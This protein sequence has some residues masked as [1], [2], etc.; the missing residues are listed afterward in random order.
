[1][2]KFE[3]VRNF[4]K[5]GDALPV[6]DLIEIQLKAFARFLQ[7]D[8][9]ESKRES[10]GLQALL[11][12]VFPI[13]SYDGR[14]KLEYVSYDLGKPRY[15]PEE[16]RQLRLT[17]ARPFRVTVRLIRKDKDEV[18]EEPIYLGELPI[19]IGGGEFIFN[20]AERVIVS[21]LHRSPGV[22]FVIESQEGDRPLHACRVIPER[23]SWLEVN[24]TKRE[25]LV[26]RIDQ[27]S[28]LPATTFLRAMHPDFGSDESIIRTFYETKKISVG[29]LKPEMYTAA[30]VV[31]AESGEVLVEAG[32]E[33]GEML[34]KIQTSSP[35]SESQQGKT[36]SRLEAEELRAMETL[37]MEKFSY[38]ESKDLSLII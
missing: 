15:S 12:E 29:Q 19:M 31:D 24:V 5:V 16:C 36:Q 37:L 26:V 21:Q 3:T 32:H 30:T 22:D 33:I 7:A 10:H 4:S 27:S 8:V 17:Y 11:E 34:S 14:L 18:L 23:G 9:P 38:N 20:G 35:V 2:I 13:E 28:K 25:I 1:M 6:P